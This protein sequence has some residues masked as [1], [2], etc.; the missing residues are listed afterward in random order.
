VGPQ[1]ANRRD[2][3]CPFGCRKH[4]KREASNI[5]V[6]D[7]RGTD[8]GRAKKRELN[9]QR[10]NSTASSKASSPDLARRRLSAPAEVPPIADPSAADPPVSAPPTVESPPPDPA[11]VDSPSHVASSSPDAPPSPW[12]ARLPMNVELRVE[13][14]VLREQDVRTSPMLAYVQVLLRVIERVTLTR[15]AVTQWLLEAMRQRSMAYRS[16]IDYVLDFL[17]VHPP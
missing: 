3:R 1:N 2:I 9:A 10:K 8:E 17:H 4:H 11:V 13:Q 6:N 14:I 16:R 15:E 5:R 7:Y 12:L